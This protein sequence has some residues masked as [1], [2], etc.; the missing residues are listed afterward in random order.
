MC[1]SWCSPSFPQL[2]LPFSCHKI[3][4][5]THGKLCQSYLRSDYSVECFIGAYN[6]FV[7]LAFVL[8]FYVVG[9]PLVTFFLLWRYYPKEA[10]NNSPDQERNEV[11]SALSFLY[12]NYSSNCWFWKV[13]E[14]VRK[15]SLTSVLVL[16]GR[17]S[18]TYLGVASIM[19]G[20]CTVI[21]AS[22]KPVSDRFEHWLQLTS[23]LATCANMNSG[24]LL[25]I[26]GENLSSGLRTD[27]E[28]TGITALLLS[29]NVFVLGMIVGK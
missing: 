13:L 20:L 16:I 19:S 29:V 25:K 11:Q 21:F 2:L 27:V 9:F 22:Y 8:L 15:L 26:P 3:C 18:R 17:E 7:V 23:L 4:G 14:L 28:G 12:E 24:L 1:F 6:N 10:Q 5:D